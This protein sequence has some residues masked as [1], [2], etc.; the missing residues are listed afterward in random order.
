MANMKLTVKD[1]VFSEDDLARV[2]AAG[3]Y[4]NLT[5]LIITNNADDGEGATGYT[6]VLYT[7][8]GRGNGLPILTLTAD[9]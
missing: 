3:E 8:D 1:F 5:R 9:A 2:T 4:N 6:L 7:D